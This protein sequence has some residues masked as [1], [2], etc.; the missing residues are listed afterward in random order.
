MARTIGSA[1]NRRGITSSEERVGQGHQAHPLMVRHVRPDDDPP[2]AL[3]HALGG[4]SRAPHRD[5]T[6]PRHPPGQ[7]G[8]G[9]PGPRE[10]RASWP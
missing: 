10:A 5:H 7:G 9:F 4:Y 3:G 2:L 8:G 6:L 1:W